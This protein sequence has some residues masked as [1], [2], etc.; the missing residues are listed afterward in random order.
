M[1]S[2]EFKSK[3]I[4]YESRIRN[5]YNEPNVKDVIIQKSDDGRRYR[6][7]VNGVYYILTTGEEY[8]KYADAAKTVKQERLEA[9]KIEKERK[10]QLAKERRNYSEFSYMSDEQMDKYFEPFESREPRKKKNIAAKPKKIRNNKKFKIAGLK[11]LAVAA[12]VG[13]IFVAKNEMNNY[14]ER[15]ALDSLSQIKEQLNAEQ[16]WDNSTSLSSNSGMMQIEITGKSVDGQTPK[17]YYFTAR[18]DDGD[19]TVR[20]DTINNMEIVNA[21]RDVANAQNGNIFEAIKAE[22]TVKDMKENPNKYVYSGNVEKIYGQQFNS[23]NQE[24]IQKTVNDGEE[25]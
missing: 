20:E 13:S 2:E 5:F 10:E 15:V 25:R 4:S 16:I 24:T 17:I 1:D 19:I 14:K 12:A 6:K 11:V 3:Y 18:T 22:K 9:A 7:I 23:N 21:V 8:E